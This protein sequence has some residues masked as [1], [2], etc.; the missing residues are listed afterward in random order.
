MIDHMQEKPKRPYL[1]GNPLYEQIECEY[2][3]KVPEAVN[4]HLD[5]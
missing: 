5:R 2:G 3:Q 1:P 4:V